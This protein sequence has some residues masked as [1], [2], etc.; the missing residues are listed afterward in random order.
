M[1]EILENFI[2]ILQGDATLTAI[3]PAANISVGPADIVTEAQPTIRYPGINLRIV[4]EVSRSVPL[5]TRDTQVQLDI[6]SNN[7]QLEIENIYERVIL[8][9]NYASGSNGQ[10]YT[11]WQ[12]LGSATDIYETQQRIW[13][14]A[15]TFPVWSIKSGSTAGAFYTPAIQIV[16]GLVLNTQGLGPTFTLPNTPIVGS[17]SVFRGTGLITVG[18]GDYTISGGT[19]VLT[20]P[21]SVGETLT[22]SYLYTS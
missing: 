20:T 18:N 3:V 14:R 13:H 5:Y 11:F 1:L 8:L 2:T 19:I 21:L 6:W 16:T 22:T 12:R 4:S 9:L 10:S 15:T 7:S 17:V